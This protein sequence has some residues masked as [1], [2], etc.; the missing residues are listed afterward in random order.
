MLYF[1]T[2]VIQERR[3]GDYFFRVYYR[4][5][6]GR[7]VVRNEKIQNEL[8]LK[9]ISKLQQYFIET[10]TFPF[11]LYDENFELV[12]TSRAEFEKLSKSFYDI[13]V[14]NPKRIP[15]PDSDQIIAIGI[16]KENE[17]KVWLSEEEKKVVKK[18]AIEIEHGDEK[19]I[20]KKFL[21]KLFETEIAIGYNTYN[22]D[23]SYIQ[24]RARSLKFEDKRLPISYTPTALFEEKKARIFPGLIN[25]DLLHLAKYFDFPSISLEF[26]SKIWKFKRMEIEIDELYKFFL[27]KEY[28]KIIEHNVNDVVIT[29]SLFEKIGN[30]LW[31]LGELSIGTL[32]YAVS[33]YHSFPKLCIM[34][35]ILEFLEKRGKKKNEILKEMEK[36]LNKI[37]TFPTN[38]KKSFSSTFIFTPCKIDE[39]YII[40][41]RLEVAK[42]LIENKIDM[43]TYSLKRILE[44]YKNRE[45]IE[46]FGLIKIID[47]FV[48]L[49]AKSRIYEK[50]IENLENKLMNELKRNEL[51]YASHRL[52]LTD[53]QPESIEC[54]KLD[55]LIVFENQFI[56]K[57]GNYILGSKITSF[58]KD[59]P[60]Y[61]KKVTFSAILSLLEG[62]KHNE[63]EKLIEKLN[64]KEIKPEELA[65]KVVKKRE[66]DEI[67]RKSL[68]D[69]IIE[70]IEKRYGKIEKNSVIKVVKTTTP[71][72]FMLVDEVLPEFIDVE[73]YLQK[74]RK[75]QKNLKF[76]TPLYK[77]F[78]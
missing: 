5:F 15:N 19:T 7:I 23:N 49:L 16:L 53:F 12:K 43:I 61:F 39:S 25:I 69:E 42:K 68:K 10:K 22:F 20:L 74:L 60:E 78:K 30:L 2:N 17:I 6:D 46:K 35:N 38:R 36:Q 57:I 44:K 56:G 14:F 4:S 52:A 11:N 70:S 71:E 32:E 45:G 64:K 28:D 29:K 50:N 3:G 40:F 26:L 58:L 67:T 8:N 31:N 27:K 33:S 41:K 62:H 59:Q 21:D 9:N 37:R 77:W 18:G 72:K 48:S 63:I 51:K 13:E 55:S 65:L 24:A 76:Q 66:S 75:I 47:N 1:K 73:W 54:F 34:R